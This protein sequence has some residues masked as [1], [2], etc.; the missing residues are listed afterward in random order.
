MENRKSPPQTVAL[1]LTVGAALLRL[2]PHPPNFAPVGSVA[3]FG[4]AKLGGWQ[5]Y[6]IPILAMLVTDPI[7]SHMAGYPAFSIATPIVY[8]CFLVNV[9]LGRLFLRNKA[10]ALR[11]SGIAFIGSLQFFLLTNAFEWWFGISNYPHDLAGLVT[12]YTE[13]L[14]FFGRTV[15]A[16]LFYSVALFSAY[17][18]VSRRYSESAALIKGRVG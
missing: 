18:V 7:L 17:A 14:P 13:A 11:V 16:D 5:A 15:L 12:C 10:G 4:G 2:V 3:L 9:L 6:V 8:F 1:G